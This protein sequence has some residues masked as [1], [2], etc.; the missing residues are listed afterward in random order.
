MQKV[1]AYLQN[2]YHLT[3][4]QAAQVIFLFKTLLS[5]FS[6]MLIMGILFYGHW[7]E[8]CFALLIMLFLR[9]T[10][11]GIHFDTYIG[12]LC[13]SIAYVGLSV[14]ILPL[15]TL[16]APTK[17][18]ILLLSGIIC[19]LIGP[20]PSKYRPALPKNR[21]NALRLLSAGFILLYTLLTLVFPNIA[22]LD[23]GFF[24]IILHSL[25]LLIAKIRKKG[26]PKND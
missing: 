6:K 14:L 17:I 22:I 9:S 24:I 7:G 21:K 20:V 15:L 19:F 3:G 4:Y 18:T 12:C 1:K 26:E 16:T 10:T 11:G 25:Q 8:Y 23:I 2:T 5:E 13:M